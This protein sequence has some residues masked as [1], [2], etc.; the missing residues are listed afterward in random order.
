MNEFIQQNEEISVGKKSLSIYLKNK[1]AFTSGN[2][3]VITHGGSHFWE[4]IVPLISI[5]EK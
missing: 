3:L 5:N 1:E 2:S 4:V